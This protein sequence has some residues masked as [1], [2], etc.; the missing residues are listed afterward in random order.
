[1]KTNMFNWVKIFAVGSVLSF[2]AACNDDDDTPMGKGEVE[3]EI[4]D[5]PLDDVDV[6]SVIITVTDVK[7]DGQSLS[8]FTKQS[9]DLKAYQEG[10]TKLLVGSREMDAKSYSNVTLVLDLNTDAN[11]N[12]P[13]TYVQTTDNT[14]YK[15]KSTTSGMLEITTTEG[16][17]VASNQKNIIV[18][19]FDVRKAVGYS[20]DEIIRYRFV[21]DDN[22]SSAIRVV[23]KSDAGT[24]KGTYTDQTLATE[25]KVIVYA[26]KKGTFNA[27]VEGQAQGSDNIL[28]ANAV[29]SA[30]VKGTTS[31]TYTLALLEEGDYEVHFAAYEENETTG[32]MSLKSILQT[33][34]TVNGELI[35]TLT[36][37]SGT[38]L[39]IVA[40]LPL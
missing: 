27:D 29:S 2:A 36:V 22:L 35:N 20:S 10:N 13:G 39:N 32:K 1:M 11:G 37:E 28:F 34:V 12:A 25:D 3:F 33:D 15:L 17:D 26:Y 40:I 30:E 5:A 6:K 4:T 18:L 19:D 23:T 24:I 31:K 9:I 38:T 7:V 8:G 16:W 14:K 21:S